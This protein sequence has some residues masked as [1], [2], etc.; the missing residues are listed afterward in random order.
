MRRQTQWA[1]GGVLAGTVMLGG[2]G[3]LAVFTDTESVDASAAAGT[4]GLQIQTETRAGQRLQLHA[5][6]Q[7]G[8][9]VTARLVGGSAGTLSVSVDAPP[10]PC[11]LPDVLVSFSVPGRAVPVEEDLCDLAAGAVEL[12]GL[13]AATPGADLV[14]RVAAGPAPR[15][16]ALDWDG[17]LRFDLRQS[18]G[19][20]S[21]TALVDVHVHVPNGVGNDTRGGGPRN[22]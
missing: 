8:V 21:D 1:L 10:G 19:G 13:D 17:A 2:T 16:G 22:G 7:D 6:H 15:Q 9:E 20:F 4:L 5:Q 18:G 11:R 3:T 12:T 14:V